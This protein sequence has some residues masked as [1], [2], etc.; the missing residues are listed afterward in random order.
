MSHFYRLAAARA[1]PTFTLDTPE[2]DQHVF[3]SFVQDEVL[4]GRRVNT[5]VLTPV[6]NT[7]MPRSVIVSL[8]WTY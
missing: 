6:V 7:A 5:S 4:V 8:L 3:N 2:S 1:R